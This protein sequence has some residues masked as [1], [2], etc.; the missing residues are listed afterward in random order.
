[1][2]ELHGHNAGDID[3]NALSKFLPDLPKDLFGVL[4]ETRDWV[5]AGDPDPSAL[6][7][8]YS[9]AERNR[10]GLRARLPD[11][12]AAR[13][14]RAEWD[15]YEHRLAE[16]LHYRWPNVRRLLTDLQAT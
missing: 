2:M 5:E 7:E 12:V 9:K 3:L 1:M 6:A 8:T 14:R 15:P 13:Q 10:K 11:T 4:S 16:P